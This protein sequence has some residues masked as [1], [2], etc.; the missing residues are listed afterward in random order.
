MTYAN[1]KSTTPN[2]PSCI[3]ERIGATG[4]DLW[5]YKSTDDLATVT[6]AGY[7]NDANELGLTNGDS[8]ICV[9][10]TNNVN[11]MLQANTGTTGGT[12]TGMGCS[13]IEPIGETSIA[14]DSNGTGTILVNAIVRFD[15]DETEYRVTVGDADVSDGG[16]ITITP[17]LVVATS[18]GTGITIQTDV[19]TLVGG[20]QDMTVSGDVFPGV[21]SVELNHATVVVAATIADAAA[22]SGKLFVVKDTSAS[23]TAAHTL[24]LTSGTF[25]GTNTIAT[26]NAPNEALAVW[27]DSAGNGTIIENVGTVALS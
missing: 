5:L 3:S 26:L 10:T 20:A 6:A 18:V 17:G 14:L 23:G 1:L 11:Y 25:D 4:G 21:A 13:A 7:I 27:F 16:T 24:T 15:G 22:H 12:G 2:V 8:V 19:I 9:D